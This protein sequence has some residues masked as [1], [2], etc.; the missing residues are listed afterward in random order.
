MVLDHID[1]HTEDRTGELR[2]RSSHGHDQSVQLLTALCDLVQQL[3][4]TTIG[5]NLPAGK[6]AP[7]LKPMPRP[8]SAVEVERARR[9]RDEVDSAM[10]D[11]GF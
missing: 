6:S 4:V 9:E 10:S 7:R 5:V 8:I 11:L 2:V 3:T 1:S